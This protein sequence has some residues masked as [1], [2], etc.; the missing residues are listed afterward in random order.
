M[1]SELMGKD[2]GVEP[3]EV[4]LLLMHHFNQRIEHFAFL[5][6]FVA[7]A[8]VLVAFDQRQSL[9][10]AHSSLQGP[11]KVPVPGNPLAPDVH[12]GLLLFISHR[13]EPA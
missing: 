12:A 5:A 13:Q 9:H 3:V 11:K 10:I 6:D 4:A 7:E 8:V 2:C 1:P